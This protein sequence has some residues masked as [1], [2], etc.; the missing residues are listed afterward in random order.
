MTTWSPEEGH[1]DFMALPL[2]PPIVSH[3]RIQ[4]DVRE[5]L[6]VLLRQ[7]SKVEYLVLYRRLGRDQEDACATLQMEDATQW[8]DDDALDGLSGELSEEEVPEGV[9]EALSVWSWLQASVLGNADPEIKETFRLRAMGPKGYAKVF[10]RTLTVLPESTTLPDPLRPP[11]PTPAVPPGGGR[12][13][14]FPPLSELGPETPPGVLHFQHLG[15]QYNHFGQL[16][17]AFVGAQSEITHRHMGQASTDLQASRAQV[18]ELL[19]VLFEHMLQSRRAQVE[20]TKV[21]AEAQTAAKTAEAVEKLVEEVGSTARFVMT[22]KNL[23][24]RAQELLELLSED[25]AVLEA[26]QDPRVVQL[27]KDDEKR[28][29]LVL[30]LKTVAAGV[31]DGPASPDHQQ[32]A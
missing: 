14:D 5:L 30:V 9:R 21:G 13:F 28:K 12:V 15:N 16:L 1:I 19:N 4:M 25:P 20:E 27:F 7:R 10:G 6:L 8:L 24:P 18:A 17:L 26:L 2:L 22:A 3:D 29:Q 31:S 23:S 11:A 32:A